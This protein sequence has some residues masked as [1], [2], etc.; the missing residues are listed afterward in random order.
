MTPS[1]LQEQRA[2]HLEDISERATDLY[3]G[4][5]HT[6]FEIG[7]PIV[8]NARGN[9]RVARVRAAK[10]IQ[11]TVHARSFNSARLNKN[12]FRGIGVAMAAAPFVY[13]GLEKLTSSVEETSKKPERHET[14]GGLN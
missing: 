7:S 14:A 1:F 13:I 5:K 10:D 8:H 11:K 6:Y 3:I 12:A 2:W 9:L 4:H